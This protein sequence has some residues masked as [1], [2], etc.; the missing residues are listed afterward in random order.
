MVITGFGV[1]GLLGFC[2]FPLMTLYFALAI[3]VLVGFV[4]ICRSITTFIHE[5][6]HGLAALLVTDGPVS[7][8]IG[9]MGDPSTS[10]KYQIG[11]LLIFHRFS[12]WHS[13]G[14][15]CVPGYTNSLVGQF[16]Y[17]LMGPIA[18]LLLALG[19]AVLTLALGGHD[20]VIIF[21][22]IFLSSSMYDLWVNLKPYPYSIKLA[23]G[24]ITFND[25]QL[26]LLIIAS[27]KFS[28]GLR[29]GFYLYHR[30]KYGEALAL[31]EQAYA[32]GERQPEL[33]S[34]LISLYV[35]TCNGE[36]G[37]ALYRSE[38]NYFEA[39]P[40]YKFN[41]GIFYGMT[42]NY[43]KAMTTFNSILYGQA[44]NAMVRVNRG[45]TLNL[46]GRYQEAITDF[47]RALVL[48]GQDSYAY[49][50]RAYAYAQLGDLPAGKADLD[51]ALKLDPNNSYCHLTK[52]IIHLKEGDRQ[53]ACTSFQRAKE[54][55]PYTFSLDRYMA[56]ACSPD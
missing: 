21:A 49:S 44:D 33:L 14:G 45:F 46:M 52:G 10:R 50:N 30:Q 39:V 40:E 3:V 27:R 4:L 7:I 2:I 36:K 28:P 5:F 24:S 41:L 22:F 13:R 51:L 6:G 12:F 17:V 53:K 16:F 42:A 8:Y 29:K 43:D 55:D 15:L 47:D 56:E 25:G 35:Q 23:D 38:K 18:S 20:I 1:E 32:A 31:M 9:S 26:L 34:H 11:R 37:L 48:T 19:I 54:L